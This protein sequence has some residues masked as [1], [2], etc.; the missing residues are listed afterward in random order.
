MFASARYAPGARYLIFTE[1]NKEK[2]NDYRNDSVLVLVLALIFTQDG[3][4]R[5]QMTR[6]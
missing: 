4:N 3:H 6:Q 5:C 2:Q 1:S